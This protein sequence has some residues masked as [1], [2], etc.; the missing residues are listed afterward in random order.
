QH[1]RKPGA[2]PRLP[3][4]D[5]PHNGH[6]PRA[7]FVSLPGTRSAPDRRRASACDPRFAGVKSDL[8]SGICPGYPM[9]DWSVYCVICAGYII[10]ALL[11]CVPGQKRGEPAFKR[12]FKCEPGAALACPYCNALLGF[13][14]NNEIQVAH[15]GWPVFRYGLAELE[16]KK[17][18]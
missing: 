16:A 8:V 6:R 10:D 15:G 4:H 9:P 18:A 11:E 12:L 3:R 1:R 13:D 14:D 7:F 5:S 17:I 2:H